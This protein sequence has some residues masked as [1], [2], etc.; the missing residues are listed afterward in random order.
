MQKI[1]LHV[2][3]CT[4]ACL[5]SCSRKEPVANP[6]ATPTPAK[7]GPPVAEIRPPVDACTLLTSA[8]IESVQGQPVQETKPSIQS[9]PGFSI[10][11][12]YFA[13]PTSSNSVVLNVTQRVPGPDPDRVKQSWEQMFGE[14][15][16]RE[17]EREEE[18]KSKPPLKVEGIG[19]EAFWVGGHIGG[20]LYVL[21]GDTYIRISV[22][23]PGDSKAKIEKSK[24]LGEFVLKRL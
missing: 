1:F 2:A 8:E 15:E 18:E 5:T 24:T 19:D 13:L 11:Q 12:C 6:T 4:L 9:Y 3:L 21:K 7:A 22:G 14:D 17:Q 20:A 10:T 23:G 16:K